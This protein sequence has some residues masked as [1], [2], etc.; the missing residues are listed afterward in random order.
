MPWRRYERHLHFSD[1]ANVDFLV[2]CDVSN[3]G[4]SKQ[5]INVAR[6]VAMAAFW[7]DITNVDFL[8][9]CEDVSN[10]VKANNT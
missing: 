5:Y 4:K 6:T 8:L 7:S 3:N 10:N 2:N 9:N 1:I